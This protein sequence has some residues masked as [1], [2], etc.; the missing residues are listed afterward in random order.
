MSKRVIQVTIATAALA[1]VP[2]LSSAA[3]TP[4]MSSCVKA[5]MSQLA[6][7]SPTPVKLLREYTEVESDT[8]LLSTHPELLLTA[9]DAHSDQP[10]VEVIC[11]TDRDGHVTLEK[12]PRTVY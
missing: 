3:D 4:M 1:A 2:M 7:T 12:A 6:A 5:L 9:R 10:L 11:T 8:P